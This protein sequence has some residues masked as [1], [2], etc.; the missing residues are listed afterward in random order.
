MNFRTTRARLAAATIGAAVA[1][2]LALGASPA[3]AA[4][5]DGYLSGSGYTYDDWDDEG[6]LSS[7]SYA[8]SNATCLWQKILWAEGAIE[9][10]GTKYDTADIDGHFGSNTTHATKNLQKRWGLSA[11]GLVGKKTFTKAGDKLKDSKLVDI[12]SQ[13]KYRLRYDGAQS[14]FFVYRSSSGK[15]SLYVD[16]AY[17]YANYKSR[18][19]S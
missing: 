3:S 6:T 10:D 4:A 5:S 19:C 8:K 16:G 13:R 17:R 12:N 14:D 15:Y 2:T 18:T 1:G 11:D 7:S 9:K